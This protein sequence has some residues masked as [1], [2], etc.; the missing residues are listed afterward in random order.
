M[1]THNQ[2]RPAGNEFR[3]ILKEILQREV[4]YMV[5]APK[6][7]PSEEGAPQKVLRL[8]FARKP[9]ASSGPD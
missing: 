3:T 7:I 6:P 8:F 9:G 2:P 4:I 1:R 5:T